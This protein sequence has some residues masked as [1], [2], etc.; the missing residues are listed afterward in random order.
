MAAAASSSGLEAA[1]GGRAGGER[2][3]RHGGA[4]SMLMLMAYG[5]LQSAPSRQSSGWGFGKVWQHKSRGNLLRLQDGAGTFAD[6]YCKWFSF[7][8]VI[9]G[10]IVLGAYSIILTSTLLWMRFCRGTKKVT[11]VL[12]TDEEEWKQLTYKEKIKARKQQQ[13]MEAHGSLSQNLLLAE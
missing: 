13:A 2:H 4:Q 10:F 3:G 8:N 5:S 7:T 6:T 9:V 1:A 12:P 11:P